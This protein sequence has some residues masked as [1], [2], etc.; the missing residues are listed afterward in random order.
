MA[1]RMT[2]ANRQIPVFEGLSVDGLTIEDLS[3]EGLS[4]EDFIFT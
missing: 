1:A 4:V 3:V 2:S